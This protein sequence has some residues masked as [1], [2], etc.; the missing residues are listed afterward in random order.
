MNTVRFENPIKVARRESFDGLEVPQ[1]NEEEVG[2]VCDTL[3]ARAE[4]YFSREKGAFAKVVALNKRWLDPEFPFRKQALEIIPRVSGF[5]KEMIE[6]FGFYPFA[7]TF[8]HPPPKKAMPKLK[9]YYD[10]YM[11]SIGTE[12]VRKLHPRLL[13]RVMFG[14]VV[15]FDAIV[16]LHGI[17]AGCPQIVKVAS[18][19]PIFPFIYANSMEAMDPELRATIFLTYWKGGNTRIEDKVF[20]RSD[21]I[22]VWGA[23]ETIADVKRRVIPMKHDP[24][25]IENP[26]RI[27]MAFISKK[28]R[29]KR[30]ADLVALDIACWSGMACFCVKNVFVEGTPAQAKLFGKK[31][32]AAIEK[33]TR[34]FGTM[35]SPQSGVEMLRMKEGYEKLEFEGK[36][37][38]TLTPARG[39]RWLVAVDGRPLDGLKATTPLAPMCVVQPVENIDDAIANVASQPEIR[40]FLEE[41]SVAMPQPDLLPLA[42]KMFD[43]GFMNVKT[44]GSVAFSKEW[45]P[46]GGMFYLYT[47]TRHDNLRWVCV[48][49]NDIDKDLE[50]N[51]ARISPLA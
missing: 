10:G 19:Q 38:T 36:D 3:M 28:Y 41:A 22:D 50:K 14:N 6:T 20:S 15:G 31:V 9:P 21:V 47:A 43:A 2:T 16:M 35:L 32:A 18:G 24:V 49:T 29:T 42:E 34:A 30:V 4:E 39:I 48:D 11:K 23:N 8:P 46:H 45:E 1:L 44:A 51:A 33:Y 7:W 40:P 5:S 26:H 27:G 12:R 25:I 13:T 37:V 17:V